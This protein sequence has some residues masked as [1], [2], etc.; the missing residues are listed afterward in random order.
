MTGLTISLGYRDS[1]SESLKKPTAPHSQTV[2]NN[3]QVSLVDIDGSHYATA[4]PSQEH[5][6]S[7]ANLSMRPP[8]SRLS[9]VSWT[10]A[11]VS[12]T[13]AASISD[14]NTI[15]VEEPESIPILESRGDDQHRVQWR[16]V[17]TPE[18]PISVA[19]QLHALAGRLDSDIAP[20]SPPRVLS[21]SGNRCQIGR[22]RWRDTEARLGFGNSSTT[23]NDLAHIDPEKLLAKFMHEEPLDVGRIEGIMCM[24]FILFYLF[25]VFLALATAGVGVLGGYWLIL[26]VFLASMEIR[27]TSSLV[28]DMVKIRRQGKQGKRVH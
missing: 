5:L 4:D 15:F 8:S 13:Y 3:S 16:G 22:A 10:T 23:D 21:V 25:L 18:R 28:I 12:P 7:P 1:L 9:T 14:Q 27:V 24:Y 19:H 17:V 20:L 6:N 2:P 26:S 11:H